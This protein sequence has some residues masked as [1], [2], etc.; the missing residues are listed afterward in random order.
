MPTTTKITIKAQE[1]RKGDRVVV[2]NKE[3]VTVRTDDTQHY[4]TRTVETI[5]VGTKKI[6]ARDGDVK[7]NLIFYV[8]RDTEVDVIRSLPT[9]EEREA[10]RRAYRNRV[11]AK[12]VEGADL[13]WQ[14]AKTKFDEDLKSVGVG[15]LDYHSFTYSNLIYA[16]AEYGVKKAIMKW[17]E[18]LQRRLDE[19]DAEVGLNLSG[20]VDWVEAFDR[21]A[22]DAK[23][24]LLDYGFRGNSRSTSQVSNILEDIEHE[25]IARTIRRAGSY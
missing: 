21:W 13:D 1:V 11:I 14:A 23:E 2:W 20:D 8:D 18:N 6:E 16:Q 25:V 4:S 22:A 5:K 7:R 3:G 15:E 9:E 17:R 12:F 24:R 10:E 19:G